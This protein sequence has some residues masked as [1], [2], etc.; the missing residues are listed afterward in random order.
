MAA[1]ASQCY[2]TLPNEILQHV[3]TLRINNLGGA[4]EVIL[5]PVAITIV[6][7]S[8]SWSR[9]PLTRI[10]I[11]PMLKR[12]V[13][14]CLGFSGI[15][16]ILSRTSVHLGIGGCSRHTQ[17]I[18]TR[19]WRL[20]MAGWS[21]MIRDPP[22]SWV[23]KKGFAT[24]KIPCES[25]GCCYLYWFPGLHPTQITANK[26]QKTRC[27][28]LQRMLSSTFGGPKINTPF[29]AAFSRPAR[30]QFPALLYV[31]T[32]QLPTPWLQPVSPWAEVK[33]STGHG[34]LWGFPQMGVPQ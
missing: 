23:N 32:M 14:L 18:P 22:I 16:Q 6:I 5:M 10:W 27:S 31:E 15:H 34:T 9:T 19:Q 21:A 3:V 26:S 4:V 7:T 17:S 24:I 2:P 28:N 20:G 25:Y 33:R 29:P 30:S 12:P 1:M 11:W 8:I 13:A